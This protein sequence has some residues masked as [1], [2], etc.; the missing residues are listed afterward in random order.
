LWLR[1]DFLHSNQGMRTRRRNPVQLV[2]VRQRG[3]NPGGSARVPVA[4][5]VTWA[6]P[7]WWAR[8]YDVLLE[9]AR[10]T[11]GTLCC[12]SIVIS[13]FFPFSFFPCLMHSRIQN[14][15]LHLT[16]CSYSF[17]PRLMYDLVQIH[18]KF[19]LQKILLS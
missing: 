5:W 6:S 17:L 2:A 16:C 11:R 13:R 1:C 4:I 19:H 3:G 9:T 8:R 7:S 18:I 10:S 15:W 12:S 14:M